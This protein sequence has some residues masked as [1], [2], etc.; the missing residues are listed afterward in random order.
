MIPASSTLITTLEE[1][2]IPSNTHKI[3]YSKD[4]VSGYT[5]ELEAVKQAIYLILNTERYA[6]PIY[7]WDYGVE[8]SDLIGMNSSLAI[9]EIKRRITDAL[10]Q[11]DRIVS[12]DGF[13]FTINKK[14]V[15]CKFVVTT[16]YGNILNET[17]VDI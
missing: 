5:D 3:I 15:H 2:E 16:I 9:P 17:E 7:S 10:T 8:F 6:F 11:D 4:R 13:E 1:V 12:V 14:K